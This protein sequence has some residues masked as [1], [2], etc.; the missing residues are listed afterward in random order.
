MSEAWHQHLQNLSWWE[1]IDR[2]F[3]PGKYSCTTTYYGIDWI[4]HLF[5]IILI[6]IVAVTIVLFWLTKREANK[7]F[8]E[9]AFDNDASNGSN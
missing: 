9:L 4:W 7:V 6:V 5:L 1:Q 3:N 8:N 2:F